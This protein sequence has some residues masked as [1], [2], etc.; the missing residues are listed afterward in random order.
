MS[1]TGR[2]RFSRKERKKT[3]VANVTAI[4][5]AKEMIEK[6]NAK[7]AELNANINRSIVNR[8]LNESISSELIDQSRAQPLNKS[9]TRSRHERR[10]S[11][12]SN[13]S[14]N[15]NSPYQIRNRLSR[16]SRTSIDVNPTVYD[17]DSSSS[18]ILESEDEIEKN[19]DFYEDLMDQIEELQ[20]K[21]REK[22]AI[23]QQKDLEIRKLKRVAKQNSGEKSTE[24]RSR[25]R[26]SRT[27]HHPKESDF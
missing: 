3:G 16:D 23:I 11:K 5:E 2:N 10:F 27:S 6:G 20:L 21:L 26:T 25:H 17:S 14:E 7:D 15:Q 8:D 18:D 13:N 12:D 1:S 22:E 19:D 24:S 9:Q 4:D